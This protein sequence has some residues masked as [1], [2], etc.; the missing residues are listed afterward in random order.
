MDGN[1]EDYI[2]EI[3]GQRVRIPGAMSADVPWLLRTAAA[4]RPDGSLFI[5]RSHRIGW[6]RTSCIVHRGVDSRGLSGIESASGCTRRG[7]PPG[8]MR[9]TVPVW[10]SS[11]HH[12]AASAQFPFGDSGVSI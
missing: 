8:L 5:G 7:D 4:R 1:P 10:K 3:E 6:N 9:Q 12:S 2:I 11:T